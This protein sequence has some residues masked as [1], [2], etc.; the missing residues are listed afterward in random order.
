M[1]ESAMKELAVRYSA[2]KHTAT[3]DSAAPAHAPPVQLPWGPDATLELELPPGLQDF[4]LTAFRPDLEG[5]LSDYPPALE[6][7]LDAPLDSPPLEH[8]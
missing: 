4:G 6:S 7:A 5:P 3:A 8:W 2:V 1:G